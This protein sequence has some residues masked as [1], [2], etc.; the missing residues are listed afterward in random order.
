MT[1][2]SERVSDTWIHRKISGSNIPRRGQ[3]KHFDKRIIIMCYDQGGLIRP[4]RS[5][6]YLFLSPLSGILESHE[7]RG[8]PCFILRVC[9]CSHLD[10][11]HRFGREAAGG[12]A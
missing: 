1:G 12:G 9:F 11:A 2:F 3:N 10:Q 5:N 6:V 4:E 7:L 8:R